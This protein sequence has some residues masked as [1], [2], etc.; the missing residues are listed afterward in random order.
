MGDFHQAPAPYLL[1]KMKKLPSTIGVFLLYIGCFAQ[2]SSPSLLNLRGEQ[3]AIVAASKLLHNVGGR[4]VWRMQ[5]LVVYEKA[6]LRSGKEV[7]LKITR[8]LART[9]RKIES[10]TAGTLNIEVIGEMQGCTW[11]QGEFEEIP[12]EAFDIER[13]GLQQSPYYIYHR[14]AMEDPEIRVVLVEDGN[15]L[16]IFEN[17]DRLLCWFLIDGLGQQYSWGNIFNGKVNQHFYGPYKQLGESRFPT[18]GTSMDGRFRF[19]Y[20]MAEFSGQPLD[21]WCGED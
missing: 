13:Q 4:D 8:N 1:K 17:E 6:F 19:E 21:I 18:W 20:I 7:D 12:K 3:A 11:T 9:T 5:S 16:N 2:E 10:R 14:L 15:R